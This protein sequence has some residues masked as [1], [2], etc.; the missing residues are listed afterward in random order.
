MPAQSTSSRPSPTEI[1][2]KSDLVLI[3]AFVTDSTGKPI[4]GL[5]ASQFKVF[6]DGN[7]QVITS[8]SNEDVPVSIGLVLDRSGSMSAKTGLIK[9][10][11]VQL[12]RAANPSD[13][14]FLVEFQSRAHV[15]VPFTADLDRLLRPVDRIQSGG[16]PTLFDAVHLAIEEMRY[17]RFPRKALLII[18]DGM[19]NH[20][21]YRPKRNKAPG[22]RNR[23][24]DLHNQCLGTPI[25]QQIRP[26][27]ISSRP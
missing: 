2:I 6:E 11:A 16:N 10:A 25:W 9:T 22:L 8:C 24:S 14:Y 23:F 26:A 19:D 27:P 3:N 1:R 18:S 17:A 13:E 15:V 5:T 7:E 12:A 21:R 20:S 4:T